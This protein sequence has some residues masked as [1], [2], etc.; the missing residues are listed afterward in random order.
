VDV[1]VER[2]V[3]VQLEA[4]V[5]RGER[6]Q[7]EAHG[8]A[9]EAAAHRRG[10]PGPQAGGRGI[11]EGERDGR[12]AGARVRVG[13]GV[14]DVF[15]GGVHGGARAPGLGGGHEPGAVGDLVVIYDRL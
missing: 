5:A 7:V 2:S 14:E 1:D 12:P 8:R 11:V 4:L 3:R 10:G 6:V 13:Q 15:G 9:Q